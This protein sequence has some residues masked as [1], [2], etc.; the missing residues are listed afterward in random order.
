MEA[1]GIHCVVTLE[2]DGLAIVKLAHPVRGGPAA[3]Q[4]ARV[5]PAAA[6]TGV[7]LT[8]PRLLRN[9][10]LV[11]TIS[12]SYPGNRTETLE[13]SRQE[14]REFLALARALRSPHSTAAS[15]EGETA[16]SVFP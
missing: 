3:G 4:V 16:G 6:V 5:L 11:L 9:G 1:H 7:E 8:P 2:R 15:L 13:F 12:E 10:T 14:H